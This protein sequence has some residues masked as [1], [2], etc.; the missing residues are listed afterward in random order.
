MCHIFS[1]RDKPFFPGS[2]ERRPTRCTVEQIKLRTE[3][4]SGSFQMLWLRRS[5]MGYADGGAEDALLRA[6][7]ALIDAFERANRIIPQHVT[8]ISGIEQPKR[9]V[10]IL[11]TT[12]QT[13]S[14]QESVLRRSAALSGLQSAAKMEHAGE[15]NVSW[16]LRRKS[17]F[18]PA[19]KLTRSSHAVLVS[20]TTIPDSFC[21]QEAEV[22]ELGEYLFYD[23]SNSDSTSENSSDEVTDN[24][25]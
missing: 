4:S 9:N 18:K 5:G 22:L 15:V 2:R 20:P 12:A 7:I 14:D 24:L 3:P 8:N 1:L 10:A 17:V 11:E 6:R 13:L 19:L 21:A 23:S 16:S 25:L